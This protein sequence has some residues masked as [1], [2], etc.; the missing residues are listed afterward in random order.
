VLDDEDLRYVYGMGRIAQ[1][2]GADT[3]Y[4]LT[5]GLGSTMALTDEAGDVVNDYDYDVFGALRD[6]SG[7]QDNDFTFAGEQIDGSTGLHY[8]RARYYDR[9]SG[10]LVS[11]DPIPSSIGLPSTEA[12]FVYVLNNPANL[13]DPSGMCAFGV[14]CPKPVKRA[15]DW[16]VNKA[17]DEIKK[18][19]NIASAVQAVS[20]FVI[21]KA[22]PLAL[23][24]PAAAAACGVAS[25]AYAGATIYKWHE[26][27]EKARSGEYND[28]QTKLAQI[29][30]ATPLPG[31]VTKPIIT[32]L[33]YELAKAIPWEIEGCD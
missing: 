33:G 2:D 13:L 15:K 19:A 32:K 26:S 14:P 7:S 22:C 27:C 5:D 30:D 1:V 3:Y 21:T 25:L 11:E 18:P 9:L 16:V 23:T 31:I 10:R 4:Y 29:L 20:G 6:S 28:V 12:R 24:G 8:L 17:V